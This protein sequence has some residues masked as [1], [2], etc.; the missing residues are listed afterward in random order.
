ML[1]LTL[2]CSSK[3][4]KSALDGYENRRQH[5]PLAIEDTHHIEAEQLHQRKDDP[6]EKQDL[7]PSIEGHGI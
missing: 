1:L 3:R 7:K 5:G 4:I 2:A 6:A